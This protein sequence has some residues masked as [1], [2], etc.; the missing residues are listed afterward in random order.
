MD[1][2]KIP[3]PERIDTFSLVCVTT[4]KEYTY[5]EIENG[6]TTTQKP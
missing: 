5:K 2:W 1:Q 4:T 6:E 3:E